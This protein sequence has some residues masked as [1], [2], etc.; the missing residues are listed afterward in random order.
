MSKNLK[1]KTDTYLNENFKGRYR[2]SIEVDENEIIISISFEDG[3]EKPR[4]GRIIDNVVAEEGFS[5]FEIRA[6][7]QPERNSYVIEVWGQ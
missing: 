6:D 5:D 1:Q 2:T 7:W 4:I 3:S